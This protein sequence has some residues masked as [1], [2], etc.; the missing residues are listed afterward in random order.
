MIRYMIRFLLWRQTIL[1]ALASNVR[2]QYHMDKM[3]QNSFT[4]VKPLHTRFSHK[5]VMN[6]AA[7]CLQD[8][9]FLLQF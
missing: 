9:A 6:S 5:T 8:A 1:A 3:K 2:S 7:L 4:A